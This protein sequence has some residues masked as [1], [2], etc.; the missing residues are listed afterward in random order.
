MILLTNVT[1]ES[2]MLLLTCHY[3]HRQ[4]DHTPHWF[5]QSVGLD[6]RLLALALLPHC[7]QL[8]EGL[9]KTW[10]ILGLAWY[11][12]RQ[13]ALQS[14]NVRPGL[15]NYDAASSR[16]QTSYQIFNIPPFMRLDHRSQ[17]SGLT[18]ELDGVI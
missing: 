6:L 10:G 5:A 2:V 16:T 18:S 3:H 15:Y 11:Y 7:F 17:Y 4:A 1:E 9:E 14:N 12:N 13:N 8:Q